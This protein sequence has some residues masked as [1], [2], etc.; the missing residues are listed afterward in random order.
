MNFFTEKTFLLEQNVLPINTENV[1]K[2]PSLNREKGF[3][4]YTHFPPFLKYNVQ[5]NEVY[6]MEGMS[7]VRNNPANRELLSLVKKITQT[8]LQ[9]NL[10]V[11]YHLDLVLPVAAHLHTAVELF[12]Q[13]VSVLVCREH[14]LSKGPPPITI[15]GPSQSTEITLETTDILIFN[16]MNTVCKTEK[17][18][19]RHE[20]PNTTGL[21]DDDTFVNFLI[22]NFVDADGFFLEYSYS[23]G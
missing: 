3:F 23:E 8:K 15:F 2:T 1:A 4:H 22:F 11:S 10:F 5:E 13:E 6:H 9:K 18:E 17:I 7:S 16:G 14:N 19:S 12:S 21:F 20:N